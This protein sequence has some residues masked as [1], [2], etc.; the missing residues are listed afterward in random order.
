MS[1]RASRIARHAV[2]AAAAV[3]LAREAAANGSVA[4]FRAVTGP[5]VITRPGSYVVTR[6][7]SLGHPGTAIVIASS[8]VTLHLAGHT[9][10]G[11]GGKQGT[12]ILVDGASAVNVLGGAVTRF[13]TGVEVRGSTNVRVEGLHVNGE[14]AGGPPPG[15]V[16]ILVFNSRAVFLERNIVSNTFLGIFVRGGGSGGNRI[17]ENTL[18]G[19]ASGQLGICYNPDGS[20]DPAGPSGD[21]VYNN[22][23]S[24]FN[25]GI[26]TS[27]G[28]SGN[29]FREN[30]VAYFQTDIEEVGPGQNVFEGNTTVALVP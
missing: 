23:V 28:T 1:H 25:V 4:G 30:D 7:I 29:I 12:G 24:R 26:Q 27:T 19:G 11:P 5:T 2:V 15:E 20:G 9:L 16:G 3:F 21:T 13:G 18:T 8:H 17:A 6:N 10:S 22:L 14:D